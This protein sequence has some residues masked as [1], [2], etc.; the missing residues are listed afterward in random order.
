M[1]EK[2]RSGSIDLI[3]DIVSAYV[4]NNRLAPADL[5]SF[6]HSVHGALSAIHPPA[7]PPE[8]TR[9]P[10]A[11]IRKTIGEDY[12]ICLE[13]G[14][15]FKSLKRH[16]RTKYALSPEG[17]RAKWGLPPD[18]PMVAPTYA[19]ARSALAKKIGLGQAGKGAPTGKGARRGRAALKT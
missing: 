6:I 15:K 12:L 13:D 19:A 4:S 11:S 18:Y 1:T 14:L 10:A 8:Q 7:A 9:L 5:P 16:L 17:Y 3:A 2:H